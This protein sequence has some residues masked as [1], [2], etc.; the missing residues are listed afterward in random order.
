M[1]MV[2]AF[3]D[4]QLHRSARLTNV[5]GGGGPWWAR[6]TVDLTSFIYVSPN[7][8]KV[9]LGKHIETTSDRD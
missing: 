9:V 4:V 6:W 1:R 3:H 2:Q 8:L 7:E 5:K